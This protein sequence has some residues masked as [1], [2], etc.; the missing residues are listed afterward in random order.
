M[1]T[2]ASPGLHSHTSNVLLAVPA[3]GDCTAE[4]PGAKPAACQ[5]YQTHT[6]HAQTAAA[7]TAAFRL[8]PQHSAR[9]AA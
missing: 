8:T 1:A 4:L 5:D 7:V 3:T 9:L 2:T 6:A